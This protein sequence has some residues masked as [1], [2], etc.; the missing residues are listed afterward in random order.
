MTDYQQQTT[1][2]ALA[3]VACGLM[4]LMVGSNASSAAEPFAVLEAN[5]T[6]LQILTQSLDAAAEAEPQCLDFQFGFSSAEVPE[7]SLFL[8]AVT[9]TLEG[10]ISG[11]LAALVTA[12]ASITQW[13]PAISGGLALDRNQIQRSEISFP[14]LSREH[15]YQI[16]YSV[17]AFI[18]EELRGEPLKFHMDLFSNANGL[19]SLAW[20]TQP[21]VVPEPTTGLI[22]LVG[23]IFYFGFK[24][25]AR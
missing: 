10:T 16:A 15:P 12:D 4:L 23:L 17:K 20:V 22:L 18:P 25:R 6:T 24:W 2:R 5:E 7:P 13:A 21:V 1:R 9:F 8:D 14:D 3:L 19:G 11:L